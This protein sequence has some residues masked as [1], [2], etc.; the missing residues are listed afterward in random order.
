MY[1]TVF[2]G[3]MHLSLYSFDRLLGGQ[4]PISFDSNVSVIFVKTCLQ[5]L[6]Q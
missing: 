4:T 1:L 5:Q 3:D 6:D 2:N